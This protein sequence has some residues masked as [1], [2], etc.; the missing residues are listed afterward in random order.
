MRDQAEKLREI[1]RGAR[2]TFNSGNAIIKK[3]AIQARVIAVTSGKGGVGKTNFT[4]NLAVALT[5]LGK[6]VMIIDADLGLG[7]VEYVLGC[8]SRY[9]LYDLLNRTCTVKD[10]ITESP[11]G[12]K[13]MSGGSGIYQL[14]ELSEDKLNEVI[15][16]TMQYDEWA[17]IILVDTGAGINRNV[18]NFVVAADEVIVVTTTEPTA[19]ADAYALMK[20][21]NIYNGT[22]TLKLVINRVNEYS[23]GESVANK[24]IKVAQ[25]F[26]GVSVGSLGFVYEDKNLVKAVKNQVPVII[27]QP[28][29]VAAR[30]IVDIAQRLL[31]GKPANSDGIAGFFKKFLNRLR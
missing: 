8:T 20:V 7:N 25:Q 13:F 12:V 18:M 23:E 10:I 26:L 15:G 29:T 30:S 3:N 21:Y 9:N 27:A 2:T 22:A 1:A 28:D 24:L 19:I 17:D 14:A 5:K 6:N 4:V 11:H 31:Y 16:Q